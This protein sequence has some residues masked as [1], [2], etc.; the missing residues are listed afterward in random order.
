MWSGC[1]KVV[2]IEDFF[3]KNTLIRSSSSQEIAP[4]FIDSFRLTGTALQQQETE[5]LFFFFC[6]FKGPTHDGMET[7][8]VPTLPFSPI[9]CR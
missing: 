5:R 9:I 3:L 1:Y 6:F 4:S 7:Y 8:P 2:S